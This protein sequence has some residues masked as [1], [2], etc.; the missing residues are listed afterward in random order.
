MFEWSA[1]TRDSRTVHDPGGEP[2][3]R[4]PDRAV[5]RGRPVDLGLVEGEVP[6]RDGDPVP[7][8]SPSRDAHAS[9]RLSAPS[10]VSGGG[11]LVVP[12]PLE[13][14][15][16][17][18]AGLAQ[19]ADR[20]QPEAAV[21]QR[22]RAAELLEVVGD[23]PVG[24]RLDPARPPSASRASRNAAGEDRVVDVA[25]VRRASRP[26]RSTR[27]ARPRGRAAPASAA[28]P[29]A[30]CRR[31][32]WTRSR[33]GAPDAAT[34]SSSAVDPAGRGRSTD[35]RRTSRSS[36]ARTASHGDVVQ[37]QILLAAC[38][39]RR[40]RGW[41]RSTPR[42]TSAR[43]PRR[44]RSARPGARPGRG[45]GRASGPSPWAARRSRRSRT[46]SRPGRRRGRAA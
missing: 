33:P 26:T 30:G 1:S 22:R 46:P 31:C 37:P 17:P 39:T 4:Q 5:Q 9:T 14:R 27:S 10:P 21:Q 16:R 25:E 6:E 8:S 19:L 2:V 20:A 15:Q 41:P 29:A 32:A 45:P 40:P 44:G 7:S 43:A 34:C 11:D 13:Q 18:P 36:T 12:Q 24:Q 3:E 42:R 38:P 28:G 35:R 23:H